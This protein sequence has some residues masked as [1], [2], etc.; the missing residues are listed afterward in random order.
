MELGGEADGPPLEL[1]PVNMEEEE[2]QQQQQQMLEKLAEMDRLSP[3][4]V[5]LCQY[6][7]ML[8]SYLDRLSTYKVRPHPHCREVQYCKC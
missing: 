4:Q 3:E 2:E 1:A 8:L 5:S 6:R 7:H